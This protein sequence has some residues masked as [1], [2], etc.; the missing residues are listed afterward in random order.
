LG[1]K[2]MKKSVISIIFLWLLSST[3][4]AEDGVWH[5]QALFQLENGNLQQAMLFVSGMSY[6]L[7][8]YSKQLENSGSP[9]LFCPS[10]KGWVTSEIIFEILNSRYSGQKITSKQAADAALDGLRERYPCNSEK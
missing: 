1:A 10:G 5:P 6:G 8:E 4:L 3:S 7:T 2:T 9:R